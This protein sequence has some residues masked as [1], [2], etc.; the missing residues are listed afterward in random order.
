M[1][2]VGRAWIVIDLLSVPTQPVVLLVC[3]ILTLPL[4]EELHV[5]EM[6][7]PV[8]LPTIVPFVTLHE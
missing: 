5:T 3:V 6:E 2:G 8:L 7:L 1:D 4:L